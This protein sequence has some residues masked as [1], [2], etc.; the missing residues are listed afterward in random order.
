MS[1]FRRLT[2]WS[3]SRRAAPVGLVMTANA[4]G[5]VGE[6]TLAV[7]VEKAFGGKPA[8][9]VL[10]HPENVA[11]ARNIHRIDDDLIGA[12]R[13]VHRN[14]AGRVDEKAVLRREGEIPAFSL[15]HDSRDGARFILQGK[16]E[17]SRARRTNVRH[18]AFEG[19]GRERTFEDFLDERGNFRDFKGF[20][21]DHW[22]Q[23]STKSRLSSR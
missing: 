9:S 5:K 20:G 10:E 23:P 2:I 16:I 22:N 19:D 21:G 15:E 12:S 11:R 6:G 8:L 18:F 13:F 3:M 7:L 14:A 1:G 4:F 17:V